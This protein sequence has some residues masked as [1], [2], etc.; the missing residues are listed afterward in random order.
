[1]VFT[2][3]TYAK[4][5]NDSVFIRL[6]SYLT[7]IEESMVISSTDKEQIDKCRNIQLNISG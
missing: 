5:A 4:L 1:M 2:P 6:N 3:Q 7:I